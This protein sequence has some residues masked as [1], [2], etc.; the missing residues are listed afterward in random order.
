MGRKL[1]KLPHLI[2]D[3]RQDGAQTRRHSQ[4]WRAQLVMGDLLLM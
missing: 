1:K 4:V 3:D 2:S